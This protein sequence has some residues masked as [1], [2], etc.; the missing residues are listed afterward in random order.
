MRVWKS[1]FSEITRA[2][3]IHQFW[4]TFPGIA[5]DIG[6]GYYNSFKFVLI[7]VR[8]YPCYGDQIW[9]VGIQCHTTLIYIN[10]L[11]LRLGNVIMPAV[12]KICSS[13]RFL[14]C[15]IDIA[16]WA[17]EVSRHLHRVISV[18]SASTQPRRHC[19]TAEPQLK[20]YSDNTFE[21]ASI[22]C[23]KRT[24]YI[25]S[26]FLF[27]V[28]IRCDITTSVQT[29]RRVLRNTLS[30]SVLW[31]FFGKKQ[32]Q[33]KNRGNQSLDNESVEVLTTHAEVSLTW[34]WI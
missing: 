18:H 23:Y 9:F 7:C 25:E 32:L 33:T 13:K 8:L 6:S 1:L 3:S 5:P 31:T 11:G 12:T 28:C 29:S 27:F 4:N 22:I 20:S 24:E 34:E 26:F 14:F 2:D 10:N 30:T 15:R 17:T 16:L 21:R 19:R